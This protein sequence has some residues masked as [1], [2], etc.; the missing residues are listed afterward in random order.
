MMG[1]GV[2]FLM[3]SISASGGALAKLAPR[4]FAILRAAVLVA[5]LLSNFSIGV[6]ALFSI[7][8]SCVKDMESLLLCTNCTIGTA[9]LALF[10]A[11]V[12]FAPFSDA[13]FRAAL[14]S[15]WLVLHVLMFEL[16]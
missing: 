12:K 2:Q 3:D 15:A 11:L 7:A 10:G 14:L 9:I 13:G 8:L 6:W 1:D 4:S 16:A 5:S